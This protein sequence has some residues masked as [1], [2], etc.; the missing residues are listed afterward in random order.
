[1]KVGFKHGVRQLLF[2]R[3]T[4]DLA[5]SVAGWFA[6]GGAYHAYY[7]WHGG[8]NY[9]RTAGSGITTMYADDVCLH[10]DGTPNEPKYTQLSRLQHLVADHAQVLLSQD[11]N[12]TAFT[13]VGW[14]RMGRLVINNMF[15]LIHHLF[16]LLVIKL[17]YQLAY[18][19]IIKI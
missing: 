9:G 16:I 6:G 10:A 15:I 7:M 4:S 1:M 14:K 13:L 2:V 5:Y 17:V 8:N 12:R 3:P 18:S 11:A 19:F